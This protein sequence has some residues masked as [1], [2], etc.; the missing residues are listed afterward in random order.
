[1]RGEVLLWT[2]R[3]VGLAIDAK[4]GVAARQIDIRTTTPGWTGKVLAADTAT[5]PASI[6]DPAW[7]QVGTIPRAASV[8][9]ADLDTGGTPQRWYL[10]WI[11][12]FAPGQE[13]VEISEVYLY[14]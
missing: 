5:L 13:K 7:K 1:M 3:G 14:R 6:S 4:P 12:A 10:I 11:T 2:S 9:R 8:T